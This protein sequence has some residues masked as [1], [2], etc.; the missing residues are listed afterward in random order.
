[1][2]GMINALMINKEDSVAV[3]ISDLKPGDKASFKVEDEIREV[4]I[5]QEIPIYHKFSVV[6]LR[7]NDLVLKYGQ[8]IGKTIC[9]IKIGQHVHT[10]NIV[11]PNEDT[12]QEDI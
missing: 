8:V 9:D 4:A 5:V 11:S 3:A 12:E 1:M 2:S 6:D 10:H 7:K